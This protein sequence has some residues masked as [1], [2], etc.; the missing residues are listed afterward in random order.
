MIGC[1]EICGQVWF[2]NENRSMVDVVS[3]INGR[4][5]LSCRP[6]VE[7]DLCPWGRFI[8]SMVDISLD[9]RSMKHI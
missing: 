2:V 5:C 1:R 7:I 8:R 6:M 4:D 9:L 3:E